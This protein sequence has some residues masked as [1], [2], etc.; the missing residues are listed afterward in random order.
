[1]LVLLLLS[2]VV[3]TAIIAYHCGIAHAQHQRA[4]SVAQ[5]KRDRMERELLPYLCQLGSPRMERLAA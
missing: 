2:S 3:L 5:H 4:I 1:V